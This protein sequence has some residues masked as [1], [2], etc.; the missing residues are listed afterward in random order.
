MSVICFFFFKQKTAYEIY[1]C[2][3]FRRVLFRSIQE[4]MQSLSETEREEYITKL[5]E[6]LNRCDG[7]T[8]TNKVILFEQNVLNGRHPSLET[9]IGRLRGFIRHE[10]SHAIDNLPIDSLENPMAK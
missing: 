2:D 7:V 3:W 6:R 9:F 5:Y 4:R 8:F 1:Q 10:F